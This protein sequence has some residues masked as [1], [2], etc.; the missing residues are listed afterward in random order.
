MI[1]DFYDVDAEL[2]FGLV[3]RIPDGGEWSTSVCPSFD[4]ANF[5]CDNR[6]FAPSVNKK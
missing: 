2:P 1:I 3:A 6:V 4:S 5:A